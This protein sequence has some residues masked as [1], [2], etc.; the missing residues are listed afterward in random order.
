MSAQP[1]LF[2]CPPTRPLVREAQERTIEE[3][4]WDFHHANPDVWAHLCR[5]AQG[6]VE[7]GFARYS[8]KALVE[9]VR[10]HV[11]VETRVSDGFKIN[12]N[13]TCYYARLLM[14]QRVVPPDFFATRETRS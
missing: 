8:I 5:F 12:N 3:R 2:D 4:F 13:Y 9:R 14:E 6:V 11:E 7:A 1:T 10:Y